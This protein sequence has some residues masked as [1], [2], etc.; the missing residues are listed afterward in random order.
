MKDP[1]EVPLT[2]AEMVDLRE[3]VELA[4]TDATHIPESKWQEELC[5]NLANA[6][7]CLDKL[8]N[9]PAENQLGGAK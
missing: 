9:Q 8:L 4:W 3:A 5:Q 1:A 7:L 2:R 6:T